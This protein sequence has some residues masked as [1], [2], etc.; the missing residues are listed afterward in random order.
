M[1][2]SIE[3]DEIFKTFYMDMEKLEWNNFIT[4]PS[5]LLDQYSFNIQPFLFYRST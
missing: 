4:F 3:R 2:S 5:L 1:S